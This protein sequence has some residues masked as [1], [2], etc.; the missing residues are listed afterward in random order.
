MDDRLLEY[1]PMQKRTVEAFNDHFHKAGL[2][3]GRMI[4]LAL[5]S[6]SVR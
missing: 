1:F 5:A 3:R 4:D 6:P 2:V